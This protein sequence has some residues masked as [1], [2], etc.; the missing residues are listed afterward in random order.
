MAKFV[1]N[2]E[3][4]NFISNF[5]NDF[6]II[7][8]FQNFLDGPNKIFHFFHFSRVVWPILFKF[9]NEKFHFKFQKL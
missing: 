9:P 1:S 4:E 2:F 3:N 6:S 5:K 7:F 8:S